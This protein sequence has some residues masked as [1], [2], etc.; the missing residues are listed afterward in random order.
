[1]VD[2]SNGVF[3]GT[4]FK[5]GCLHNLMSRQTDTLA[6]MEEWIEKLK[7]VFNDTP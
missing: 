3:V 6:E 1:M 4:Q 7:E 5:N 2:D